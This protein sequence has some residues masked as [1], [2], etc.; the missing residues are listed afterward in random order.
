MSMTISIDQAIN[1]VEENLQTEKELT[2]K[3]SRPLS[4]INH[5]R[6]H[7][8]TF[9]CVRCGEWITSTEVAKSKYKT[10]QALCDSCFLTQRSQQRTMEAYPTM[11]DHL[12]ADQYNDKI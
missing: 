2:T 12:G 9:K 11:D 1:I 6:F 8:F 4:D 5:Q 7:R 3:H 10:A